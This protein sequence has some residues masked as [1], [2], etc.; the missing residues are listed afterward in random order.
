MPL[1]K[2]GAHLI[3]FGQ[4]YKLADDAPFILDCVKNAG[5]TALEGGGTVDPKRFKD[6]LDERGIEC[7]GLHTNMQGLSNLDDQIDRLQILKCRHLCNSGVLGERTVDDWRRGIDLLNSAGRQLRD[8][9]MHL[10]YHNHAFEFDPIDSDTTGMD[11]L[12]EGLDFEAVDFCIDIGWLH[13]AGR[14]PATF[15]QAHADQTGYLH[16]KDCTRSMD[17]AGK[18]TPQW[19]EL[20][21]GEIDWSALMAVIP[22]LS[23]VEWALVEQDRTQIEPEESLAISRR[24][25]Q[26]NF[27]Y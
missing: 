8:M 26:D 11:L 17:A 9:G 22:Q 12:L 5:Y 6:L 27:D 19:R 25:L 18:V 3:V 10:H 14:D 24:F 2:L 13:I 4:K 7:A 23:K 20:G 16:L 15:L 1:P 21:R